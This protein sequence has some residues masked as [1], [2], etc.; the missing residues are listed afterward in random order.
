MC[1]RAVEANIKDDTSAIRNDTQAL[2]QETAAIQ[3]NTEEILARVMSLRNGA[4]TEVGSRTRQWVDSMAV[5][6]SYAESS[7]QDTVIDLGEERDIAV[8]D[9]GID[10]ETVR[11]ELPALEEIPEFFQRLELSDE[12]ERLR[13]VRSRS[14]A[15]GDSIGG[16]SNASAESSV[17]QRHVETDDPVEASSSLDTREPPEWTLESRRAVDATGHFYN[18]TRIT[19]PANI[20]DGSLHVVVALDI[21]GTSAG[22]LP[23]LHIPPPT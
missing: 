17:R 11:A 21:G 5:L 12:E 1:A 23:S 8:N 3:V 6:S 13:G 15:D 14:G 18:G 16:V 9:T 2:R 7:Y 20:I 22:K 19:V 4:R 10:T